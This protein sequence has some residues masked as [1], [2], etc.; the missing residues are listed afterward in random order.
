M[1]SQ[2]NVTVEDLLDTIAPDEHLPYFRGMLYGAEGATKTVTACSVGRPDKKV[3]L[4]ESDPEGYVSLYNHPDIYYMPDGKTQRVIRFQYQGLSQIDA[5]AEF[6]ESDKFDDVDTLVV[7]TSSGIVNSDLDIITAK[8]FEKKKIDEEVP[9]WPAYR[10]N[11]DRVRRAFTP[12]MKV[13][14]HI[15]LTSHARI[16]KDKSNVPRTTPDMPQAVRNH[17]TRMCHLVGL[18]TAEVSE[19]ADGVVTYTRQMQVHPTRLVTAKSRIGGLP[20]VINNP[21]L[22]SIVQEWVDSGAKLSEGEEKLAPESE[23]VFSLDNSS[24]PE[25]LGI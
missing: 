8:R 4:L 9:D 21:D 25:G 7:D 12:L 13:H 20:V 1:S 5:F 23:A 10:L 15:I 2:E 18:L 17:L 11:Q 14:K 3:A 19:T 22:R 6:L 16:E 24:S